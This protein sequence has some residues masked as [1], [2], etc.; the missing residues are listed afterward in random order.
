[1]VTAWIV[2]GAKDDTAGDSQPKARDAT[3][4]TPR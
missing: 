3:D 2:A 1:M 4:K